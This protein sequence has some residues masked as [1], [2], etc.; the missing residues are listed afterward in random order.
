[1]C[2]RYYI[3]V[4]EE[5]LRQI[6]R[7]VEELQKIRVKTGEIFPTDIAPVLVGADRGIM[8]RGMAWGFPRW[9]AKGVVFN[10][11]AETALQ[12]NM[13]RNAL[14]THPAVIPTSGF[15]EWKAVP[16]T[17]KK[18][19]YLFRNPDSNMLYLAGF[20]NVF[21]EKDGPIHE[22]F[23]VL[24]TEAN[25]SVEQYHN[26]M[27]ILLQKDELNDWLSGARLKD[28]LDRTPFEVHAVKT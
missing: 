21:A 1:M 26:R 9:N 22:R 14:L 13:F 2:G 5:E 15:Y 20:Y 23:T 27:P 17:K 10:A 3:D 18:E 11:R 28:F 16:D 24:T 25:K 12:K 8:P 6:C 4:D 7:E 19:K